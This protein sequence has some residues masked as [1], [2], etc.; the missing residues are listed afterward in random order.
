M[1]HTHLDITNKTFDC[2]LFHL[3]NEIDRFA[4]FCRID[5]CSLFS[6]IIDAISTRH[7]EST[8]STNPEHPVCV[9]YLELETIGIYYQVLPDIVE[10]GELV[11]LTVHEKYSL[12]TDF[13]R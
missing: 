2:V 1:K 9:R 13:T 10:I 4:S 12:S 7:H 6:V 11:T 8:P 3:G 5:P